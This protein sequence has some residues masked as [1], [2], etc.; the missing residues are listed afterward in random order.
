MAV[1]HDTPPTRLPGIRYPIV[2]GPF[3]GGH[4]SVELAGAVTDAGGMG[5]F[6]LPRT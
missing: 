4:S 6:G 5:S 1:W 3:G 2:Q